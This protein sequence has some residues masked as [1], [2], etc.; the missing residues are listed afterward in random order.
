MRVGIVCPY[1]WD[2][3][4]GV[5]AHVRDLAV[6]LQRMGHSVSVLAPAE[7]DAVLPAYVVSA[8]RPR[9]LRYNGSVARV[10]FGPVT[11]RRVSRCSAP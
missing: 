7:D 3:P 4:G 9:A 2:T 1:A 6:A 10:S 5:S 11:A 8:G